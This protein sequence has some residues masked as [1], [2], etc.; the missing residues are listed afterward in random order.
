MWK[1]LA[2]LPKCQQLTTLQCAFDDTALQLGIC[3]TII[4]MPNLLKMSFDLVFCLNHSYD[5]GT[6]LNQLYLDQHTPSAQKVL[7]ACVHQH[8]VIAGSD[9]APTLA[10]AA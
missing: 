6:G 2:E 3:A 10:D 9:S 4:A 5:L 7:K 1:T 8:Q